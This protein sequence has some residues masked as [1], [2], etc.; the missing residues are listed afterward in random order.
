LIPVSE[1]RRKLHHV[2]V[3]KRGEDVGCRSAE[4]SRFLFALRQQILELR[5]PRGI[6]RAEPVDERCSVFRRRVEQ[7]IDE[8]CEL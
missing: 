6:A 4:E 1:R 2:V 8:R 7:R 3:K 5:L